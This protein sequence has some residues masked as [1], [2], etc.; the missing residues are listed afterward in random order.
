MTGYASARQGWWRSLVAGCALL[1]AGPAWGETRVLDTFFSE[2]SSLEATFEQITYDDRD[3]IVEEAHGTFRMLRPD[4]FTWRY[5]S[6]YQQEVTADG[7]RLWVYD[8]EL[9]QVSVR[10]LDEA[11][12]RTPASLLTG[13]RHPEDSFRVKALGQADGVTWFRLS[14]ESEDTGF[15]RVVLGFDGETPRRMILEDSFGNTTE[16]TFSEVRLNPRLDPERFDFEPP[17]GA[18]VIGDE[19]EQGLSR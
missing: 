14:P 10:D 6:P 1:L 9:D 19:A 5:E 13:D 16:L 18:D 7:K 12:G 15:D 2:V 4:R 17:E 3:Q 11:L 8:V